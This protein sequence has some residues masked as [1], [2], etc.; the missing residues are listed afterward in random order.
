MISHSAGKSNSNLNNG[1]SADRFTEKSDE[2][3][4]SLRWGAVKIWQ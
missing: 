4:E 1:Q 3:L 2:A